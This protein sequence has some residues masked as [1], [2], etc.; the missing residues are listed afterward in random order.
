MVFGSK[1]GFTILLLF[2]NCD[3]FLRFFEQAYQ[4]ATLTWVDQTL[5]HNAVVDGNFNHEVCGRK[6]EIA[7][8]IT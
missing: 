5:V 7:W 1:S 3:T 2:F 8:T 4:N 6:N